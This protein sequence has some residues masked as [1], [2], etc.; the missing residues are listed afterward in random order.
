VHLPNRAVPITLRKTERAVQH[1]FCGL[2]NLAEQPKFPDSP[3]V[4]NTP[5]LFPSLE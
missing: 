3:P 5:G 2:P 1:L 4:S